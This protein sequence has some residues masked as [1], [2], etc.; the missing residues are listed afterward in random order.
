MEQEITILKRT[1]YMLQGILKEVMKDVKSYE[2]KY[3]V[4]GLFNVEEDL[5][6]LTRKKGNTDM[7]KGKTLEELT[8]I[9]ETLKVKI[10]EKR[11]RLKPLIEEHKNL[12]TALKETEEENKRKRAEYER[13]K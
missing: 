4:S 1:E 9:V 10:E 13:V 5:E 7:L 2:S 12:K 11:D 3:G 8:A 6:E